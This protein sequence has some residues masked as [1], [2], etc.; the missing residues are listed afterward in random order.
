MRLVCPPALSGSLYDA[1]SAHTFPPAPG[2]ALNARI[3]V[4][5]DDEAFRSILVQALERQGHQVADVGSAL[6]AVKLAQQQPFDL[7]VA[8]IRMEGKS[9]LDAIQEVQ[10]Q[11][12]EVNSIVITG[13]STEADSIRAVRLGVADYL[14]KPFPLQVFLDSVER[15][16]AR[17]RAE[18]RSQDQQQ[19][20][21]RSL[22]WA[23]HLV[24]GQ[25]DQE[26]RLR[27]MQERLEQLGQQ[28]GLSGARTEELC[29]AFLWDQLEQAG[30]TCPDY[31]RACLPES[32][33]QLLTGLSDAHSVEGQLVRAV[34][35]QE[36][37]GPLVLQA[38]EEVRSGAQP[39]LRRTHQSLRSLLALARA[40]AEGGKG[41]EAG[42]AYSHVLEL[43]PLASRESM[44]ACLGL[45]RL[46]RRANQPSEVR[47]YGEQAYQIAT[48]LGP[49]TAG[50]VALR[51][52]L[53]A[54]EPAWNEQALRL[55]HQTEVAS[56]A[57]LAQLA[58]RRFEPGL[59]EQDLNALAV[60]L[61]A[62]NASLLLESVEWLLP[63]L[64]HTGESRAVL[65]RALSA[66][67][68]NAPGELVYL[69]RQ[70]QLP[71]AARARAT[72]LLGELDLPEILK[73]LSMD[74]QAEVRQAASQ[75]MA[76]G[77]ATLPQPLLRLF[78][79]GPFQVFR[80]EERIPETAWKSQK[81]RYLL[82]CLAGYGRV[83]AEDLLLE[84]FWPEDA[85]KGKRNLYTAT[86]YLRSTLGAQA[87]Y[88]VRTPAGLQ[89]NPQLPCWH[90][91]AEL[92]KGFHKSQQQRQA[93]QNEAA[94]DTLSRVMQLY[95]GPYL[96]G[97]YLEWAV[98]RRD[99][100]EQRM[101]EGLLFL[102]QGRQRQQRHSEALEV[103]LRVLE[104]DSCCQEAYRLVMR[105]YLDGGRPEEAVRSYQQARLLL[106]SELAM[107]PSIELM[108]LH[109]RALLSLN[110]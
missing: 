32:A 84:S 66:L 34:L 10:S 91:L 36:G 65:D 79:L 23:L 21:R 8:D 26:A 75:A 16:L 42:E 1:T 15:V 71:P 46:H 44:E 24:A 73:E 102:A 4:L 39:A 55:F 27:A 74:P 78:S 22:L 50:W 107:E 49:V 104:L 20:L 48:R 105:S 110:R 67:A 45:A 43:E 60:L 47:R 109:Q 80:G 77:Q 7:V 28:L 3:L 54:G 97:C 52:S 88:V 89:I 95:R 17:K 29:L 108:E 94:L 59:E 40:L 82:A 62:E 61:Q 103:A 64:L 2:V 87:D 101:V 72:L 31:V 93:G 99:Q 25:S 58:W 63:I 56:G 98:T 11:Q 106:A 51:T 33:A 83:V 68:R 85:E 69:I 38:L 12:P 90:D 35:G 76:R 41:D 92:E 81:V 19:N 37:V 57:A 30:H 96:E 70:G 100:L 13:Y 18:S 9:G 6:G 14:K 5:E 86:S 53:L